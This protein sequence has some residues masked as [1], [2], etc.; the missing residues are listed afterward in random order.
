MNIFLS[1][2][3]MFAFIKTISYGLFELQKNNNKN[4]GILVIVVAIIG[5]LFSNISIWFIY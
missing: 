4:G 2:I 3:S 5:I 1:I